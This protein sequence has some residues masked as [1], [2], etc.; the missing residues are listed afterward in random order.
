[1]HINLLGHTDIDDLGTTRLKCNTPVD[2]LESMRS[3]CYTVVQ[4]QVKLK[5]L[6]KTEIG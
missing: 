1:M 3:Q 2:D 5:R 6:Q 4:I